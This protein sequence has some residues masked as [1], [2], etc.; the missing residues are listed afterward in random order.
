MQPYFSST[1]YQKSL[2]QDSEALEKVRECRQWVGE[3][4]QDL[5]IPKNFSIV[6]PIQDPNTRFYPRT[7]Y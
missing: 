3:H 5:R 1:R 4:I 7:F 6:A 2:P